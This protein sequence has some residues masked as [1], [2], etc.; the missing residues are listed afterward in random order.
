MSDSV[1]QSVTRSPIELFWTA[2][3]RRFFSEGVPYFGEIELLWERKKNFSDKCARDS[4]PKDHKLRFC[5]AWWFFTHALM[6]SHNATFKI[7]PRLGPG[8]GH[9]HCMNHAMHDDPL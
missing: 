3:N 9:D 8:F 1:S 5:M 7:G 6:M 4:S 2:K